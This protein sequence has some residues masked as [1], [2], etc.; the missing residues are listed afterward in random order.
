MHGQNIFE[1]PENVKKMKLN[2]CYSAEKC[3]FADTQN[4]MDVIKCQ[5]LWS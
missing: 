4:I 3:C 5:V 1:G 2:R